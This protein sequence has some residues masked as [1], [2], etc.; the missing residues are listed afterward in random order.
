MPDQIFLSLRFTEAFA[1]AKALKDSLSK[2]GISCF[3]CSVEEGKNIKKEIVEAIDACELMV[4]LGT[5]TYGFDT[6]IGFS[7]YNELEFAVDEKKPMFLV[8]MCERFDVA[9]TRFTLSRGISYYPWTPG[10]PLDEELVNRIEAKLVSV[11]DRTDAL[12]LS[13]STAANAN[14]SQNLSSNL[15]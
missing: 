2:R 3:L 14:L 6:G 7:T 13:N 11:K 10:S 15:G 9:Y 1:E 5:K 4:V 12:D 8:K